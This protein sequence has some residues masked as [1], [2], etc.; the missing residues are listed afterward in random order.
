[1]SNPTL[2]GKPKAYV[3][4]GLRNNGLLQKVPRPTFLQILGFLF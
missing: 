2:L 3:K 1:M 4:K